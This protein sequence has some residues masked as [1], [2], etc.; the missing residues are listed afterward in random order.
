MTSFVFFPAIRALAPIALF[1]ATCAL[2]AHAADELQLSATSGA[3]PLGVSI[4]GPPRVLLKIALCKRVLHGWFGPGGNGLGVD[5][6]D[7]SDP[8]R[9]GRS[10]AAEGDGASCAG[11][12]RRHVYAAPGT[13]HL[14]VQD[15]HP[16]PTDAVVVDWLGEAVVMVK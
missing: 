4:L 11:A 5:W 12:Q 15:W 13:Y 8:V 7:G 3:A 16:G 2:P 1:L 6:G 10:A 9:A 14:K